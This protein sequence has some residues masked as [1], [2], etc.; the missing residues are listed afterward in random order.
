MSSFKINLKLFKKCLKT[1]NLFSSEISFIVNKE[2]IECVVKDSSKTSILLFNILKEDLVSYKIEKDLVFSLDV[3][4]VLNKLGNNEDGDIEV[5]LFDDYIKIKS[6]NKKTKMTYKFQM[7]LNED[8]DNLLT[9]NDRYKSFVEDYDEANNLTLE[10]SLVD[11][12]QGYSKNYGENINIVISKECIDFSSRDNMDEFN[13][14]VE[15]GDEKISDLSKLDDIKIILFN[16]FF[17]MVNKSLKKTGTVELFYKSDEEPILF[18]FEYNDV[19]DFKL[20][21]SSV[22]DD[23]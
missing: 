11:E 21:T 6:Q 4:N 19:V 2:K 9:L 18:S 20:I 3:S 22:I 23:E 17:S 14:V 12:V 7:I 15:N 16:K 5:Q 1:A 10:T 13:L 8:S